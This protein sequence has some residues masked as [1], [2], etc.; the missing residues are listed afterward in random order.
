MRDP[1]DRDIAVISCLWTWASSGT[2][3]SSIQ[4]QKCAPW[5]GGCHGAFPR[6]LFQKILSLIDDLRRRPVP[7]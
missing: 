3:S 4:A 2:E 5:T 6:S 1:L 7:A